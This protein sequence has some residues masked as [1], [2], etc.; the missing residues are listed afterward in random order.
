MSLAPELPEVLSNLYQPGNIS[1][2]YNELLQMAVNTD[3]SVTRQWQLKRI[4]GVRLHLGCG[5]TYDRKGDSF[6]VST[7]LLK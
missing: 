1:L 5:F 4:Q 7:S 2:G 6:Q 3:I